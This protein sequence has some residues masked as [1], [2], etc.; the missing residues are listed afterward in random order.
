M[1]RKCISG[2]MLLVAVVISGCELVPVGTE[3]S[4]GGPKSVGGVGRPVDA[5]ILKTGDPLYIRF[6]GIMEQQQLE[7]SIDENGEI[8][9][10][11]L[12]P[13]KA[14]GLTTSQLENEIERKYIEGGIYKTLSVHV[15]MTAKVY[16]VQGEV[17]APGQYQLL[18]GTTLLQAIANARGPNAYA[19]LKKVTITRNGK[20]YTHNFKKIEKDPSLDVKIEAGDVI[21]VWQSRI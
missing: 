5:Y 4:T 14:A 13:I 17:N 15:T 16:Y 2:L 10:L 3:S 9:L 7:T 8:S 20:I 6:S 11:H 18:S 21:K 1:F 12:E 19:N